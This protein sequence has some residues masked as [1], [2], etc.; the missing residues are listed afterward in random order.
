MFDVI[1]INDTGGAFV[2]VVGTLLSTVGTSGSL[3]TD[4]NNSKAK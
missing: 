3:S 1:D 2:E 4:S